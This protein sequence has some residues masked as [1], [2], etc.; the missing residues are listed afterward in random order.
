MAEATRP[1]SSEC[2]FQGLVGTRGCGGHEV[3]SSLVA[4][5]WLAAGLVAALVWLAAAL[6]ASLG[7]AGL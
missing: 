1:S 4:G 5:I 6:V 7:S 3:R 2:H